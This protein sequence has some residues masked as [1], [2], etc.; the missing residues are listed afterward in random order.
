MTTPWQQAPLDPRSWFPMPSPIKRTRAPLETW[1]LLGLRQEN[2]KMG[3]KHLALLA[4]EEV[5]KPAKKS[6]LDGYR[7]KST[8][9]TQELPVAEAR[10]IEP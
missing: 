9:P 5:L 8:E 10:A 4:S 7:R 1:L 6:H 2:D 3:Q